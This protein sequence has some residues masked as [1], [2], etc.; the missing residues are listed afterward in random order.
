MIKSLV[1]AFTVAFSAVAFSY[2]FG[3]ISYDRP[4]QTLFVE[5]FFTGGEQEHQF[6]VLGGECVTSEQPN[7][8]A[9]RLADTGWNDTGDEM[10]SQVVAIP[11][12]EKLATCDTDYVN[13]SIRIAKKFRLISVER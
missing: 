2:E 5:L 6:S 12:S 4:T 9:L 11:L 1:L 13:V 8:M 10:L 3:A 7:G